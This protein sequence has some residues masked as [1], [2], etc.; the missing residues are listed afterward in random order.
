VKPGDPAPDFE[1]EDQ[2]PVKLSD[3][4]G[5]PVVLYFYPRADTPHVG[6]ASMRNQ[7]G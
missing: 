6:E 5:S 3:L 2:G 4:K 1:L 7:L